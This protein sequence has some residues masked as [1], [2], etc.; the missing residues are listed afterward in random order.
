MCLL[1]IIFVTK[2]DKLKSLIVDLTLLN[3]Y[4]EYTNVF[5]KN[6]INQLSENESHDY[7]I[8]LKSGKTALYKSLYNLNKTELAIL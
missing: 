1:V 3:C 7:T 5:S 2:L 4:K 6:L 8:D